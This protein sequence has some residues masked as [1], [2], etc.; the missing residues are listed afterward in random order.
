MDIIFIMRY[1]ILG[2][3]RWGTALAVHLSRKGTKVLIYDINKNAVERIN[4]GLHPYMEN[5]KISENIKGTTNIKEAE[6]FSERIIC[7]LPTQVIEE[8][9]KNMDLNNKDVIIASKGIDVKTKKLISD[10]IG[11]LFNSARIYVLSGPSFA[12]E[13]LKGL[14]TA[15]VLA[16]EDEERAKIIQKELNAETFRVY[17]SKDLKGVELGGAL[18]NVIAI[19]CGISDGL[20]FGNNARASLITRGLKE[21]ARIGVSLGAE[22]K[23]FYGLSGAGDLFLTASS[24]LSRNRTFGF[25]LARGKTKEEILKELNQTVEGIETVKAVHSIVKEKNIYAPVSEAVYRV[26]VEGEDLH[27]VIREMLLREPGEE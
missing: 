12:V 4:R 1:T 20:G 24:D 26:V 15:L 19:A 6:N 11:S 2:G 22:E 27:K 10:I 13:V 21:M 23:T 5:F 16:S 3:G 17:R 14:P 9:V 18:K 25:M 7:A 8:S